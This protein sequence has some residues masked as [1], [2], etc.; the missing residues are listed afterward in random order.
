MAFL[1]RR[2]RPRSPARFL[3]RQSVGKVF[4]SRSPPSSGSH[5]PERCREGGEQ[6]ARLRALIER[7]VGRGAEGARPVQREEASGRVA[8]STMPVAAAFAAMPPAHHAAPVLHLLPA[9]SK[10][11]QEVARNMSAAQCPAEARRR[12]SAAQRKRRRTPGAATGSAAQRVWEGRCGCLP[13]PL[14]QCSGERPG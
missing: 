11:L 8:R 13:K 3:Q 2:K 9:S 6:V 1:P 4:A 14:L 10:V 12:S 7:R 5:I